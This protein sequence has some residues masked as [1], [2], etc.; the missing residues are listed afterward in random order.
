LKIRNNA[1]LKKSA[2][3]KYADFSKIDPFPN[4]LPS[5]L[6][7]KDIVKYILTTGMID[8]FTPNNLRGA[9]YTCEFSG[10]YIFWDEERIKHKHK[11]ST[12]ERL[13][14]KPNSIVFLGIKQMFNIPEYMVL[15][16][17]LRVRNAYKGLLL[18]TGPIIDPGYTGNLFIPLHNLT[19]NK[20]YIKSNAALID[21]EF[22]K[23]SFNSTWIL[24]NDNLK[25]MIDSFKFD[26]VPYIPK[27]FTSKRDTEKYDKYIEES[28]VGDPEF[29]KIDTTTPFI[30]S[31][32][33]EEI[34]KIESMQK[35]T[36]KKIKE[37][38]YLKNFF[39]FTICAV[40][41]AGLTLFAS[42]CLYFCNA[43]E[44]PETKKKLE[45]QQLIIDEQTN[46]LNDLKNRIQI[47][48]NDKAKKE[49]P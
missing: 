48:E 6:N 38:D 46:Y 22:T 9:T 35:D 26:S 49:T 45:E 32:L 42:T 37:I 47:L 7:S 27:P 43:Y 18:G 2:E 40:I 33:Q 20:Y 39:T 36:N 5:L 34:I 29:A 12:N 30:N 21:V 13:I 11:L 31:S 14:I 4:I 3:E 24:K 23:L 16:F 19:S 25:N 1:Y 15:R 44:I 10:E 41:I 28:L 8:P 17:N